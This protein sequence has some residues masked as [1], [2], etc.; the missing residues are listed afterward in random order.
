MRKIFFLASV[1]ALMMACN[2]PQQGGVASVVEVDR[3]V[4]TDLAYINI[5]SVI[6]RSDI[7]VKEGAPLQNKSASTQREWSATEQKLQAEFADLSQKFQQ[8]LI[9]SANAQAKQQELEQRAMAMQEAMQRQAEQLD[10]ENGVFA[11]RTQAL[12]SQAVQNVNSDKRYRMIVS[13][14]ALIDAD[15]TLDISNVVL[16][17]LNRLYKEEK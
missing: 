17:E 7:F 10:E 8:G 2:T 9:T 3:V 15:S 5:E 13:A 1:A 12:L 6:A 11:N 14:E 4:A 16:V